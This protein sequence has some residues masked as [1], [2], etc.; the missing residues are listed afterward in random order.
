MKY[1]KTLIATSLL[2]A[3]ALTGCN[4]DSDSNTDTTT[5][6]TPN[7]GLV[8][9][10]VIAVPAKGEFIDAK[11]EGLHY[12]SGSTVALTDANGGYTVDAANPSVAFYLGGEEG[13]L[14]GSVSGRHISTPFETMGT[15]QRAVNLSRLLLT[16]DT[17]AGDDSKIVIPAA[18]QTPSDAVK[19]ALQA[20][21]L[22]DV[23][24]FE[25]LLK[26]LGNTLGDDLVSEADAIAHMTNSL[27]DVT[28]GSADNLTHWAKGSN[29][30]FVERRATQRV[31]NNET[32]DFQ[33]VIH[34]DR[35]LS[36][37]VFKKTGGL[38]A[39][40]YTLE[41]GSFIT[42]TGS[43]DSTISGD[44]AAQYM[45]CASKNGEFTAAK[46]NHGN[47]IFHCDGE[48]ATIDSS[49][50][51]SLANYQYEL[52]NPA[53][54]SVEDVPAD[55]K[56]ITEMGGAY[57]CMA[58]KTCSEQTLTKF[59]TIVRDDADSSEDGNTSPQRVKEVIS[60]SYDPI[61]D[62]YVQ[63]RS[64][65]ELDLPYKGRISEDISFLYPVE[66]VGQDRYVDFT[67]TWTATETRPDCDVVAESTYTFNSSDF[68]LAGKEIK[69][70]NAGKCYLDDIN[71]VGEYKDLAAMDFWWFT[72]NAAGDAKATLD[73]LNT[74]VRWNDR[75]EDDT[76]DSF[77]INRFS[78]IPAG[79]EWDR[80]VLVRDT[81][82]D[83]GNKTATILMQKK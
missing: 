1:N 71:H 49:F 37:D 27:K 16:I 17:Q 61:T 52:A 36:E 55:W 57:A 31:R 63:T 30:T 43:N 74:T 79:K 80:G 45:T 33:S 34:G 19:T 66:A 82:D 69:S 32:S 20:I 77:K 73:Q 7:T 4:S 42:R 5:P 58:D 78:Y 62:V 2:A 83:S 13:L 26:E 56:Y 8:D 64:K 76:Q 6:S 72:T 67:G 53:K 47:D 46:D 68:T 24:T 70:D 51:N 60:G 18:V 48:L 28:R 29:W 54:T 35:T 11:V 10:P 12:R 21:K 22:D 81:L 65:E 9:K 15:H 23:A 14:L 40:F 50:E 41:D 3:L 38:S 59:E 44:F 25:A 39:S 75:D